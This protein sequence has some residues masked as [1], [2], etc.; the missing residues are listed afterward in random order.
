MPHA[1]SHPPLKHKSLLPPVAEQ[2]SVTRNVHGM[3]FTDEFA[4]LRA[5]NWQEVLRDPTALPSDIRAML[6]A[7]NAYAQAVLAPALPLQQTLL[8][9]MRARILEEDENPPTPDGAFVYYDRFNHGGQHELVCRRPRAGGPE[10]VMIDGDALAQGQAFFHLGS[11]RHSPDHS[12]LAWSFDD[13]GSELYTLRFRDI[14][15]GAD[16]PDRIG[17]TEGSAVWS[18]DC[19]LV[20]YIRV[21]DNHRPSKVLRHRLGTDPALDETVYEEAD[22]GFFVNVRALQAGRFAAISIHDHD[23]S[24]CR[25]I[26]LHDA[27][28]PLR[29]IEPRHPGMRYIAEHR[30]DRLYLRTN[31]DGAEDFKLVSAP[32]ATPGRAHWVDETAHRRGCMIVAGTIFAHFLVWLERE[33]GLPRI[34]IRH[35]GSGVQHSIAFGEEAYS[36]S[37]ETGFEFDTNILRFTYSSMTTPR[38]IY[39]Y[40]M[41]TRQRVL[42]KRQVIPSGHDPSA[43]VTR[44]IHALAPDGES[45]PVSILF[46]RDRDPDAASPLLLYGYGAYGHAIPAAF[47]ANRLLLVDRGFVYAI[48][49]IRGGTDKGWHW[50]ETGKLAQKSNTFSDFIAVARHMIQQGYTQ[51][52]RIIAHGGSAGGLLM[53]AVANMAPELFAGIIADVPFVDALTTILDDTL[54]LT[55]PEWLEWGNPITDVA[56]F[57]TILSYS[58]YDNVRAQAYPAIF[59]QGGLSDPRVTYWEPAKWVARLRARMTGGGPILLKTN[60]DAGHGGASGRFDQLEEVAQD[61]AFALTQAGIVA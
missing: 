12:L 3:E 50:Y 14:A 34:V 59:A 52:G 35:A 36:L 56:A 17:D 5:D 42:V 55:P 25:L 29:L 1:P 41:A 51:A 27:Q 24:E 43:Y 7:E 26:D 8:K 33:D 18:A 30:G 31:A 44:R 60:M 48:A 13:K 9:E 54:P 32:L 37:M 58:P 57:R 21:D 19:S 53:G 10:T 38:E 49:H 40:D 39:D 46:R 6:E 16:L 28:A 22:P 4:W 2:R 61:Y 11:T 20:Y 23:S 45:V 47:S 15:T